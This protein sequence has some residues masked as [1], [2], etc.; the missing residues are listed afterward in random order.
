ME[1]KIGEKFEFR[2][3]M[4]EV[5]EGSS[6]GECYATH[7][8]CNDLPECSCTLRQDKQD[9]IFKEHPKTFFDAYT[10]LIA[11]ADRVAKLEQTPEQQAVSNATVDW[12]IAMRNRLSGLDVTTRV[13]DYGEYSRNDAPTMA[14]EE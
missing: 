14:S 3:V 5:V 7:M 6:C 12:L 9:V 11:Q 4:L 8:D 2:G 10:D 13:E 1:K